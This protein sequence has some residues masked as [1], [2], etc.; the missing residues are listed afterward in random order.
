MLIGSNQMRSIFKWTFND[1]KLFTVSEVNSL[2]PI[3]FSF[4]KM[5]RQLQK[6]KITVVL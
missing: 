6:N 5:L 2:S 4:I 1:L 3:V